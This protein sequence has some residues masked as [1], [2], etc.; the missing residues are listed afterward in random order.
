MKVIIPTNT[1]PNSILIQDIIPQQGIIIVNRNQQ[2]FGFVVY[3]NGLYFLQTN[4]METTDFCGYTLPQL[5]EVIQR[6]VDGSITMEYFN[7]EK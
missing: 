1:V 4:T 2:P 3:S 5:L 6:S 7:T